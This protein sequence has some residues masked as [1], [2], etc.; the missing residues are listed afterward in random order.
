MKIIW[1]K[2]LHI[3]HFVLNTQVNP[4]K[5]LHQSFTKCFTRPSWAY[6]QSLYQHYHLRLRR[7]APDRWTQSLAR[8]ASA[9]KSLQARPGSG[10]SGGY[11]LVEATREDED[12]LR[13]TK[14]NGYGAPGETRRYARLLWC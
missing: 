14:T 10:W 2:M 13:M 8:A 1:R 6:L 4:S 9:L 3:L 5:K 12:T 7:T 11:G